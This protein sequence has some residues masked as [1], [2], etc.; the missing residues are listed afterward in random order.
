MLSLLAGAIAL[1][2][3]GFLGAILAL[4]LIVYLLT[5]LARSLFPPDWDE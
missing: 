2:W 4:W 5:A 3:P 1:I